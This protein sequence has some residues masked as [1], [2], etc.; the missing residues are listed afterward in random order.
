MNKRFI[1]DRV[2]CDLRNEIYDLMTHVGY[3]ALEKELTESLIN[4]NKLY[5]S[6]RSYSLDPQISG[7][8]KD[9]KK[10][11]FAYLIYKEMN[12]SLGGFH[13]D[14]FKSLTTGE[15]QNR[16]LNEIVDRMDFAEF[17]QNY[18]S[19]RTY[20]TDEGFIDFAESKQYRNLEDS[21]TLAIKKNKVIPAVSRAIAQDLVD[22][23]RLTENY[24]YL[25][26][27][28]EMR[29]KV[30]ELDSSKAKD[31]ES[32]KKIPVIFG[33]EECSVVIKRISRTTDK[34]Q[35]LLTD[36]GGMIKGH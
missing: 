11:M 12:A 20:E 26:A 34:F 28:D 33:N 35:Y 36:F 17:L 10:Q 7:P 19:Y 29:K 25:I 3:H 24:G 4:A 2:R 8:E 32:M 13:F 5:N 1:I 23:L 9:E 15:L 14:R 16:R 27:T 21:I 22:S 6:F 30:F 18:E 31:W